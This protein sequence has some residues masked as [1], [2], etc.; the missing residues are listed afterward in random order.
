LSSFEIKDHIQKGPYKNWGKTK[1]E[2]NLV[3]TTFT[4]GNY[5]IPEIKVKYTDAD[6]TEKEAATTGLV[7]QV[8]SVKSG[9]ED[10][11]DIRDIKP[12]LTLPLSFWFWFFTLILPA[13]AAAGYFLY[14]YLSSKRQEKIMGKPEP[15]RPPHEVA[16]ERLNKL[17]ELKLIE[18]EKVKEHYLL[19]SEI[20]RS[21]LEARFEI[22]VVERTTS[23][24]YA[25]L[26]D[27]GKL[28]RKEVTLVKDFLEECDLVKFA[29]MIPEYAKTDA[30]YAAGV[31]IV[32][33]TRFVPPPPEPAATG[34]AQL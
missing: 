2:Y 15:S 1:L 4:T 7:L 21:Y 24:A 10:K 12:P 18:Q 26:M 17:K 6:G 31:S 14:R 34:G 29:K 3:L 33:L 28:K 25:E 13:L 8:E 19:L 20:I 16:Y 5:E 9:P 22:P 11:D 23:E 30:D 32:D 27:S